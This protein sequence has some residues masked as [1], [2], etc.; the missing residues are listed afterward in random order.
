[1][2]RHPAGAVKQAE[3]LEKFANDPTFWQE[4]AKATSERIVSVLA[5]DATVR[6]AVAILAEQESDPLERPGVPSLAPNM[7]A[8]RPNGT[9]IVTEVRDGYMTTT[10]TRPDGVVVKTETPMPQRRGRVAKDYA[11]PVYPTCVCDRCTSRRA[12]RN[13]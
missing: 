2:R 3:H 4:V 1:M 13:R 5:N 9:T 12:A 8:I 10:E 7:A 6:D 11:T